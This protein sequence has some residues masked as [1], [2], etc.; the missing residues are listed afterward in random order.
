[1]IRKRSSYGLFVG[2]KAL[3]NFYNLADIIVSRAGAGQITELAF[4]QKPSILVPLGKEASRG[5]QI[6]NAKTLEKEN[7]AIVIN[8][9]KLSKKTFL[10][11]IKSLL[12]NEQ[13]KNKLSRNIKKFYNK[14]SVKE[15]VRIIREC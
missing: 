8:S 7:A 5:D 12:D 15:I 9:D 1:M 14:D 13:L 4:L 11:T 10:K 6:I 3:S 2:M